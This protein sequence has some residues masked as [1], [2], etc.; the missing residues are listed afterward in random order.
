MA[1]A[2]KAEAAAAAAAPTDN[3]YKCNKCNAKVRH[4]PPSSELQKS[5]NYKQKAS[6]TDPFAPR[7]VASCELRV[8]SC[9]S[10]AGMLLL[11]LGD[12]M[13]QLPYA[14]A[15]VCAE[16]YNFIYIFAQIPG[17]DD[18]VNKQV[19]S[20]LRSASVWLSGC[21]GL[22]CCCPCQDL[23]SVVVSYTHRPSFH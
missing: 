3:N 9:S 20:L 23:L 11:L 13:L 5:T 12:G 16:S 7:L 6:R 17:P 15:R 10:A 18:A 19:D 8:A 22:L 21:C 1:L 4:P 14:G 2:I